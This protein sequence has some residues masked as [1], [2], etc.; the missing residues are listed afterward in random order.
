MCHLSSTSPCEP[1]GHLEFVGPPG[2]VIFVQFRLFIRGK[3]AC[4]AGY[5]GKRERLAQF[6]NS[7]VSLPGGRRLTSIVSLIFREVTAG[8]VFVIGFRNLDYIQLAI[9][10]R[11]VRKDLR[12]GLELRGREEESADAHHNPMNQHRAVKCERLKGANR[13]D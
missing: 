5:V 2:Q 10:L 7:R 8:L 9:G 13:K 12:V 6:L 4:V 3:V 1:S 11:R